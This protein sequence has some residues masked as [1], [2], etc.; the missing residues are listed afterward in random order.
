MQSSH[1]DEIIEKQN[2]IANAL[3][4]NA[5]IEKYSRRRTLAQIDVVKVFT[6]NVG[7]ALEDISKK[8]VSY[9]QKNSINFDTDIIRLPTGDGV[10]AAFPFDSLPEIHLDFARALIRR[11][12]EFNAENP[13]P[14]FEQDGWC[15]CHAN[16]NLRFGLTEG[17][18]VIYRD[19]N[20]AY[21]VAGNAVNLSARVMNEADP[22]QILLA[23]HTYSQL[24]DLVDDPALSDQFRGFDDIAVKHGLRIGLFQYVNA[25]DSHL[26]VE[27][28]SDPVLQRE[29]VDASEGLGLPIPTPDGD[30]I[31]Q[32]RAVVEAIKLMGALGDVLSGPAP[33]QELEGP[34]PPPHSP[35]EE[36]EGDAT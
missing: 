19:V 32:G 16:H 27:P 17:K 30:R 15:N 9:S 1:L 6:K 10:I 11:T 13:C 29:M 31:A 28:P 4:A 33:A 8:Y 36:Q 22:N 23:D 5:D 35:G 24:I 20:D 7:S 34:P 18:S 12:G 26:N 21:N 2:Q 25:E 3:I 14:R